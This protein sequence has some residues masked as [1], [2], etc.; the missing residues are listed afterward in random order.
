MRTRVVRLWS[1]PS[2]PIA[3]LLSSTVLALAWA[4]S[5]WAASYRGLVE[6]P[7]GV[8]FGDA[9][10]NKPLV[11]W[12]NDG[13]MGLFFFLVGL[14][15]KREVLVGELASLRK[16]TL[17]VAAAVGGMVLP[18]LIFLAVQRGGAPEHARG[19]G[20]PMATDI[21]FAL[22]LLSL[23]G[24]RVPPSLRIFLTALAIVDDIGAVLV[25]AVFYTDTIALGTLAAGLGLFSVAI[26]ANR[27]GVRSPLL[28][29]LLGTLV[30]LAF[31]K[32]GVHATVAALL[33]AFTIPART[34]ID[35]DGFSTD[36]QRSLETLATLPP[37]AH[38]RLPSAAEQQVIDQV[39][40]RLE[41]VQA[42]LQQLEHQLDPIV[43]R[44]VLPVFALANAGVALD[45]HLGESLAHPVALGISLGLL[46]G[47]PVG[48]FAFS[49]LAVKLKL[50]ELPR[51]A[52]LR[53]LLGVGLL[54][55]VGFTMALFV[56][57]LAF[58]APM[59]ASVSKV[60]I[61]SGSV[62]AALLGLWVLS[63]GRPRE[64]KS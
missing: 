31:L 64:P 14:E 15:I 4:N 17:S 30:W 1:H 10:L 56:S 29:F 51:G 27:R 7:L 20:I 58:D 59:L 41:H 26:L 18:A 57:G 9:T 48:V 61:L 13:L 3:L 34:R 43:K 11:L 5:R 21:A 40:T 23:L 49:L 12:V 38:E 37:R 55:G 63:T 46:L 16:A 33:M 28:Y 35:R 52:T 32:S 42:P 6:L 50:A 39:A 22:G 53:H 24:P 47:K 36:V 25:I 8:S 44:L 2:W 62:V 19:W 54:A 60:G 45:G